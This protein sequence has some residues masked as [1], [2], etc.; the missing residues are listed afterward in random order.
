M[1]F[2][3]NYLSV[4]EVYTLLDKIQTGFPE[5]ASTFELG[6]S[7]LGNSIKGLVFAAPNSVLFKPTPFDLQPGFDVKSSADSR[8]SILIDAAHHARELTSVS[9]VMYTMLRFLHCYMNNDPETKTVLGT[10]AIYFVPMVNL[11]GYARITSIYSTT[12]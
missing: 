12:K 3:N 6:K 8:P 5:I 4:D 1:W 10:S 9:Q 2:Q 11:D 7:Y